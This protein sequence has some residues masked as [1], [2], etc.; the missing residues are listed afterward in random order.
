MEKKKAIDAILKE[1]YFMGTEDGLMVPLV[2]ANEIELNYTRLKGSE[3]IHRKILEILL[4]MHE[5]AKMEVVKNTPVFDIVD[6]ASIPE[7]R[8]FP[9]RRNIM[10]I[11]FIVYFGILTAYYILAEDWTAHKNSNSD[12]Y[13]RFDE[14]IRIWH[15]KSKN[16]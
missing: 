2:N 15:G 13:Q 16:S 7:R 10:I 12:V 1:L 14:L 4:P 5:N 9:V 11:I 3:I 8:S 6:E